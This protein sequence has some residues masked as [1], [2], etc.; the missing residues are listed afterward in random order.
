MTQRCPFLRQG[1]QAGFVVAML[2]FVQPSAGFA[3]E[4]PAAPVSS[5]QGVESS[6][7]Q[8][9]RTIQGMSLWDRKNELL[10]E[11]NDVVMDRNTSKLRLVVVTQGGF[12]G[13]G[14]KDVAIEW[15]EIDYDPRARLLRTRKLT[16]DDLEQREPYEADR[17]DISIDDWQ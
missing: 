7:L 16:A 11:V 1:L 10:G 12:L 14:Q 5:A 4:A 6:D 3:Q 9:A 8:T 13:I 17:G 15:R 2:A